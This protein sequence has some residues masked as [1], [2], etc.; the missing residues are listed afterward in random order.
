MEEQKS[1][2][3]LL[4]AKVVGEE[5]ST[6]LEGKLLV[7]L[8][9]V[10][11]VEVVRNNEL[12]LSFSKDFTIVIHD[13]AATETLRHLL[14]HSILPTGDPFPEFHDETSEAA[15]LYISDAIG[16]CSWSRVHE[17]RQLQATHKGMR[18]SSKTHK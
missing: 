6:N 10:C 16:I 9:S 2:P 18:K 14:G 11:M 8:N 15:S 4:L 5:S 7:N 13:L 17:R 1:R 12:K 3:W